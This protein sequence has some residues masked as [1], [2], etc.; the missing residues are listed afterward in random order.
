MEQRKNRKK[1]YNWLKRLDEA[2]ANFPVAETWLQ[3]YDYFVLTRY[4]H[5]QPREPERGD[6][7]GGYLRPGRQT[8]EQ[9]LREQ[10]ELIR[11]HAEACRT[12]EHLSLKQC[13]EVAALVSDLTMEL[14]EHAK[15]TAQPK[16]LRDCARQV[17]RLERS[18]GSGTRNIQK[19]L[20]KMIAATSGLDPFVGGRRIRNSLEQISREIAALKLA[21]PAH[22]FWE[23][24]D[25]VR[26]SDY[27]QLFEH[28]PTTSAMAQLYWLFRYG[29][30]LSVGESEVRVALIRNNLWSKYAGSIS[31][32]EGS[33]EESRGS[34]AVRNAVKRFPQ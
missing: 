31:Y 32:G 24:G 30:G 10:E 33:S 29:C 22:Y 15:W 23:L 17:A 3:P 26:K 20:G 16:Q 27:Y 1:P 11:A 34:D 9:Q 18:L 5:L 6:L 4:P 7:P 12:L 21:L 19:E 2:A 13:C 25:A 8:Y 28:D 14:E